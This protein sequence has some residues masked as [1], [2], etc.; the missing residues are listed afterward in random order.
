MIPF[1]NA[2]A[3]W[4]ILG[5]CLLIAWFLPLLGNRWFAAIEN[6]CEKLAARKT[7]AVIATFFTP[8]VIRLL[9]L[10][11]FPARPPGVHD[12]FS[13]LL[14][15]DTFAHGRLAN[16]PHPMW[17]FFDSFHVLQHPTYASMYP[18]A[19]G[20]VLA[21]GQ[22]LGHPWISVLVSMGAMFAALLWMLQGWIPPKWALLGTILALLQFGI[23]SY[24]MNSYWGGA[25]P[26]IGGALVMGAFP[27]IK[28]WQRPIDALVL[29]IGTAIL[30]NSRPLE[31]LIL[32]VPV[33]IALAWWLFSKRSPGWQV[34]FPRVV[35]PLGCILLLTLCFIGYYNWRVTENPFQFPHSLDDQLHLSAPNFVWS[36]PKPPIQYLNDQFSVFYNNWTR[37]QFAHTWPDFLR[38]SGNK[39][40]YFQH[41]FLG[42]ALLV[43]FLALPP[44]L[45]FDRR[46]RLLVW[47]FVL[48]SVGMFVVVWFNPHYAAPAMA[49][50][51]CLLVQM[52]RH[53]RRWKIEAR[54]VGI[55]LTRAVVLLTAATF[56][57]CIYHAVLDHRTSYG[58]QWGGPNWQRADIA[59]QLNS[60]DGKHLVIVR[61]TRR[62][63]N[64]FVEW[65]YNGA[66]ID[67]SKVVWA[68]EIPGIDIAPLLDYF[69][70][71]TIWVLEPDSSNPVL[72]P[73]IPTSSARSESE[74]SDHAD[75]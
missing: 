15:A 14:A 4:L 12:E 33:A 54:P 19:Q 57:I 47:Q 5:S 10:P 62:R 72:V 37:S 11:I 2:N 44:L 71:R 17:V 1:F 50:F 52:L 64:S 53:M 46:M 23:F 68:R 63:H 42:T 43:P 26:A 58:L 49:T 27:R 36:A 16:P 60:T 39:L 18:P 74:S 30:S 67:H 69:K 34:T 6:S 13:Y 8:I 66:D 22:L 59:A 70:G 40:I 3:D 21:I 29:G 20:S 41:F 45:L 56:V 25:V 55:G 32:C 51:F 7:L 24:W 28:R 61:Y 38:I 73:F 48:C 75:R 35:V 9:L 65:V 31:G